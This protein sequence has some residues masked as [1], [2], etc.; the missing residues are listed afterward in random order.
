MKNRK[1]LIVLFCAVMLC[2]M[3]FPM[4]AFAGGG[5][6]PSEE[7]PIVEVVPEAEPV[8]GG[9]DPE[10]PEEPTPEPRPFTPAG[11]AT[12]IDNATDADGKEFYTIMTP[13]ENVFYLIIDRQRETENVYFL[14][15]VT[16]QDLLALAEISESPMPGGSTPP[17]PEPTQAPEPTPEPVPEPEPEKGGGMGMM[18]VVVLIV[19]A[20]GGAAYYFK[21]YRPKQERADMTEDEDYDTN[22]YGEAEETEDDG[23]PWYEDEAE[24]TGD[25]DE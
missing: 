11:T 4:T 14:N 2:M 5:E 23:P 22:P 18:I 3:A 1:H 20:G 8:T 7:P 10:A 16:E 9:Y 17:E 6:E 13:N 19:L 21:I 12:V 15:A 25:G 24:N